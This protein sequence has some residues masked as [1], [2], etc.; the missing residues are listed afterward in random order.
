LLR[1]K[2]DGDLFPG[3]ST[4]DGLQ[5]FPV[6]SSSA[7]PFKDFEESKFRWYVPE[8]SETKDTMLR[9]G[10]AHKQRVGWAAALKAIAQCVMQA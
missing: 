2:F 1:R 3:L 10:G 4:A 7:Q 6:D 8:N 9:S 5:A